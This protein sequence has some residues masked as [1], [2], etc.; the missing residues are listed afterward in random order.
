[1][2]DRQ[3]MSVL[4]GDKEGTTTGEQCLISFDFKQMRFA[5]MLYTITLVSALIASQNFSQPPKSKEI[6]QEQNHRL[7]SLFAKNKYGYTTR[8]MSDFE[9]FLEAV[10]NEE[11]L[12]NAVA[13]YQDEMTATEIE[14]MEA[15][16]V[17]DFSRA[18]VQ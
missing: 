4:E 14:D 12:D 8:F 18:D 10:L 15:G 2:G 6:A 9:T 11:F 5:G 1:M 13:Y 3:Y 16:L 7:L 17:G